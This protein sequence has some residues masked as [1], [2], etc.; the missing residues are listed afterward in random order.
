M[1]LPRTGLADGA[2]HPL[3]YDR[4]YYVGENDFYAPRD[5][6]G[7]FKS[8]DSVAEAFPDTE[9]CDAQAGSD[10]CGIRGQGRRADWQECID[11]KSR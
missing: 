8:Y 2:G 10:P 11:R 4:I 3:H 9:E 5:A 7:K 6:S 1:V